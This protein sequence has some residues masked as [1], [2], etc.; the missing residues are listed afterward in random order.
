MMDDHRHRKERFVSNL[1]GTTLFETGSVMI[2]ICSTYFLCQTLKSFISWPNIEKPSWMNNVVEN[3]T[4]A[5]P[6]ICVCTF[7]S[8]FSTWFHVI[9]WLISILISFLT[10]PTSSVSLVPPT[11]YSRNISWSN[12]DCNMYMYTCS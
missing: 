7:L 10:K 12:T 8:S 4:L 9:L 3:V 2:T 11:S 5:I 1:N 6:I